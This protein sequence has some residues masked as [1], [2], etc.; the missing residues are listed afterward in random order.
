[1]PVRGEF[2]YQVGEPFFY[3]DVVAEINNNGVFEK[4]VLVD[5]KETL[6]K[7]RPFLLMM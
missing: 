1:M 5:R 4:V 3:F 7:I 6:K 2:R